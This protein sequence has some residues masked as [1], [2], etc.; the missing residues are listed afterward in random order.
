MSAVLRCSRRSGPRQPAG[1]AAGA[2]RAEGDFSDPVS[3]GAAGRTEGGPGA[4][5]KLLPR[6]QAATPHCARCPAVASLRREGAPDPE[7]QRRLAQARALFAWS[8]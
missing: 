5:P 8:A 6:E 2:R 3:A 7:G 1:N 4:I